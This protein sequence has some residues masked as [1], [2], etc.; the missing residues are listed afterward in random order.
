M[1]LDLASLTLSEKRAL[2]DSLAFDLRGNV[3]V[4]ERMT[5]LWNDINAALQLPKTGRRSLASFLEGAGNRPRMASAVEIMDSL[6]V[7]AL[8]ARTSRTVR[9]QVRDMV[10]RC[11]VDW[12][13]S[14]SIPPSPSA[15]LN[16][17]E[18]L[19]AVVDQAFP[20]YI[21]AQMLHYV[22]GIS[23]VA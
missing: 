11:M 7:Q 22:A 3:P 21:S 23:A 6:L 19:R 1:S 4:D 18:K 14:R 16:N 12:L 13:R 8:P 2:Y 10:L 9:V 15:M 5:V 17:F 20:G